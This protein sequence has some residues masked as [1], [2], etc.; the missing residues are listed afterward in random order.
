[1]M[2]HRGKIAA[3]ALAMALAALVL[4]SAAAANTKKA[5]GEFAQFNNCSF[6]APAVENCVYSVFSGGTLKLGAMSVP[7]V[8]PI[9][10]EGGFSGE[11]PETVFIAANNGQTLSK[12]PQPVPGGL[13]GVEPL[14]WWPTW[15]KE[16]YEA[17]IGGGFTG[18]S[19][20]MELAKPASAIGFS[21]ENML[22]E[23]GVGLFL[24]VKFKLNNNAIFGSNCY[25]G[26]ATEPVLLEL[27]TGK[28]GS[29]TGSPGEFFFNEEFTV[30]GMK[31]LK[32]VDSAFEVP[33]A[34]GC[35]GLL[36]EYFDPLVDSI[37]SLPAGAGESHAK[38]EGKLE[39]AGSKDVDAHSVHP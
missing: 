34:S 21:P 33:A 10:L 29:L 24:P 12:T 17:Q 7:V 25:I 37:F 27:T 11:P 16:Y 32:L 14:P 22:F 38:L 6:E 3:A 20:T 30:Y 4:A 23:E 39:A 8:N 31:G 35:G 36:S 26:S 28:S 13:I 2:G 15:V 1:M 5:T 18:V 9:T 19:M